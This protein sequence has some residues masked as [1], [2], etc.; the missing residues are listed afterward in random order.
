MQSRSGARN[1]ACLG[2]PQPIK[3]QRRLN[4]GKRY[5]AR[6]GTEMNRA[7]PVVAADIAVVVTSLMN[8]A[9]NFDSGISRASLYESVKDLLDLAERVKDVSVSERER[10]MLARSFFD[11]SLL[12]FALE[13]LDSIFRKYVVWPPGERR[14]NAGLSRVP[15]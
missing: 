14:P 12:E 7:S 1:A 10:L 3:E 9:V 13:I 15:R 2:P 5:L 4:G 8:H 11:W 6:L